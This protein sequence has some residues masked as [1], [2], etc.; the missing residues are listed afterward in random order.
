MVTD[1]D[2]IKEWLRRAA[3]DINSL[4]RKNRLAT[5][6]KL[7]FIRQSYSVIFVLTMV[8]EG[9]ATMMGISPPDIKE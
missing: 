3:D 9:K 1:K 6:K 4:R 2:R 5:D 7:N 8:A